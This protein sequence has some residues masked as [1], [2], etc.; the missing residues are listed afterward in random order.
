MSNKQDQQKRIELIWLFFEPYRVSLLPSHAKLANWIEKSLKGEDPGAMPVGTVIIWKDRVK[1]RQC[2]GK[3]A[4]AYL[5]EQLYAAA[6]RRLTAP[7]NN[8]FT[9][10]V[11]YDPVK[12]Q[13]IV[14]SVHGSERDPWTHSTASALEPALRPLIIPRLRKLGTVP[15]QELDAMNGKVPVA[16]EEVPSLVAETATDDVVSS[17]PGKNGSGQAEIVPVD[18][19]DPETGE[20][21]GGNTVVGVVPPAVG[22]VKKGKGK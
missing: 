18:Y 9:I 4:V 12:H 21:N 11:I 3:A 14:P 22:K 16:V 1:I 7:S 17:G 5:A 8:T 6:G 2:D 19:V 10:D 20:V 15:E 13:I